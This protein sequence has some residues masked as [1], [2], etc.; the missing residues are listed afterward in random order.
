MSSSKAIHPSFGPQPPPSPSPSPDISS[1]N[2]LKHF[3]TDS[4]NPGSRLSPCIEEPPDEIDT[5]QEPVQIPGCS[6]RTFVYPHSSGAIDQTFHERFREVIN[7]FRHNTLEDPDLRADAR[8]IDYTL[9]LC[10]ASP[11]EAQPSI[12]VFCRNKEFK[13]LR[14]LLTSKEL[15]FQYAIRKSSRR[16]PWSRAET[17]PRDG[18]HRPSFN[19]YFWRERIPRVLYW[20]QTAS[21]TV[22]PASSSSAVSD[23]TLCGSVISHAASSLSSTVGCVIT[24]G[25]K[26]YAITSKHA[27]FTPLSR[28]LDIKMLSAF[29]TTLK[30]AGVKKHENLK[31]G[32]DLETGDWSWSETSSEGD[33]YLVDD[34]EYDTLTES[35]EDELKADDA[36]EPPEE[37]P[38]ESKSLCDELP[39]ASDTSGIP[40]SFK[41][42]ECDGTTAQYIYRFPM[43]KEQE[44]FDELD[45]DWA[46]ISLPDP[47]DR[48]PNLFSPDTSCPEPTLHLLRS[49]AEGFP[50]RKTA[51]YII[52]SASTPC[53]GTL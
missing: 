18:N 21:V 28:N 44:M 22:Q 8:F 5:F 6:P 29:R 53:Q 10:G 32:A 35:D 50:S 34:V 9:R 11:Q 3:P 25:T 48:R 45:Y 24:V 20:G 38:I 12:L 52:T 27:S 39:L 7:I 2:P 51:V 26:W 16:F 1:G 40:A 43:P 19:L 31:I 14:P 36:S 4:E 33:H 37:E 42:G 17:S 47:G 46:I 13:Y 15:K 41:N 49:L 30:L 23:L